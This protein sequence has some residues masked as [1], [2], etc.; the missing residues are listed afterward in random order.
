MDAPE[1]LNPGLHKAGRSNRSDDVESKPRVACMGLPASR[2][3]APSAPAAPSPPPQRPQHRQRPQPLQRPQRPQPPQRPQRLQHLQRPRRPQCPQHPQRPQSPQPPQHPQRPQRPR[4]APSIS[5]LSGLSPPVPSAPSAPA[6]IDTS[7]VARKGM[8]NSLQVSITRGGGGEMRIAFM[9]L[10][11]ATMPKTLE[12]TAFLL[13]FATYC[14]RMW[15]KTRCH[16]HPCL[17]RPCPK[18]W[19]LQHFR[20]FVQHT[21]QGCGA[22]HVVISI[23]AFGDHVQFTAFLFFVQHTAQGCGARHVVTIIHAFGDHAQNTAFAAFSLLCTTYPARMW[24][25]TRFHKHPCLWRPCPKHC[26]YSVF[27]SLYNILCK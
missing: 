13:L 14:A 22:R 26:I 27:A 4:S 23:H 19:Y 18:H 17:W 9:L 1:P 2:P 3:S 15:S 12:F 7:A 25:K 16:W 6:S 8:S 24:S 10:P 21:A 20:F 11:L 5:A